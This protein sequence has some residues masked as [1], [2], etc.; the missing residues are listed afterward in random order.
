ME[1]VSQSDVAGDAGMATTAPYSVSFPEKDPEAITEIG[2]TAL[3][4]C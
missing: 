4:I 3:V 1:K 2:Q